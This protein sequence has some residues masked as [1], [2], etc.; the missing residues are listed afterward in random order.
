MRKSNNAVQCF[1]KEKEEPARRFI[2]ASVFLS[3]LNG[4]LIIAGAWVLAGIVYDVA[5]RKA[6]LQDVL[7]GILLLLLF[8]IS[9][10]LLNAGADYLS[11]YGASKVRQTVRNDIL[12]NIMEKGPIGLSGDRSGSILNAYIDGVEALQGYYMQSLPA[13]ITATLIP[14]AIFCFIL[15]ID[16]ISGLVLIVTAPLIPVFMIW[17]G[18]GAERLSQKQWRRMTFMGGRF[19]DVIQGLT[20]IKLFNAGKREGESIRRLT[21]AFRHDTMSVLRVAFLSSLALEFFATVSIAMIAVLIGFRLLWGEI[22][23]RDGFFILLLAPE[24]YLPLRRMGTHYHAKMDAIGA[25]E[26]LVSLLS[27][28]EENH[29]DNKPFDAEKIEIEFRNVSFSYDPSAPVLK[30]VNLKIYAGEK[31]ALVGP[32]GGGKSTILSL[33]LGFITP[34]EGKILLNGTPMEEI[35]LDQ[36]RNHLSWIGQRTHL[37]KDTIEDNIGMACKTASAQE[38][39]DIMDLCRIADLSDAKIDERGIGISGGQQQ[40]VGL[41]RALLRR[42]PLLLLDEPTAHLDTATENL[43]QNAISGLS[44]NAT[45]IFAAHR[46]ATLRAADRILSVENGNVSER[47]AS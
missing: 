46:Q 35:A 23:F 34:Q 28:S 40:R 1:L 44:L 45:V 31:I 7:P 29:R 17:I 36:W 38:I 42:S 4:A 6:V 13:R 30:N 5:F 3:C 32:S 27:E 33:L 26:K 19:L 37:F 25:S 10:G 41:A 24:F 14:L 9:R 47:K 21:E 18:R 2:G 8:Y 11:F 39:Q 15:P 43:I 20:E 22:E 16:L 12:Q